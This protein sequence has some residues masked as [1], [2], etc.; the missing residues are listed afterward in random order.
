M[1]RNKQMNGFRPLNIDYNKYTSDLA[2]FAVWPILFSF[3]IHKLAPSETD[4]A[5]RVYLTWLS[6][7]EEWLGI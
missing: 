5:R 4:M 1:R 6:V 2:M 7:Q 3:I